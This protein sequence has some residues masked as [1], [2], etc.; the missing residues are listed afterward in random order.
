MAKTSSGD[1]S[2]NVI[3]LCGTGTTCPDCDKKFATKKKL[4]LHRKL[5]H[6]PDTPQLTCIQC[7]K[8]FKVMSNLR[9]HRRA[10]HLSGQSRPKV[11]A[12]SCHFCDYKCRDQFQLSIHLRRHTRDRPFACSRCQQ[13]FA[14]RADCERHSGRCP[15]RPRN[16]CPTCS[17]TF[18]NIK[19]LN[20]H[21]LWDAN[22]G[23]LRQLQLPTSS[24][25]TASVSSSS[26]DALEIFRLQ[27]TDSDSDIV[28]AR[29]LRPNQ[30]S[31]VPGGD[32]GL[33]AASQRRVRCGV[34]INCSRG[35]EAKPARC[36]HPVRY[37]KMAEDDARSATVSRTQKEEEANCGVVV[38]PSRPPDTQDGTRTFPLSGADVEPEEFIMEEECC[39]SDPE[40]CHSEDLLLGS[41]LSDVILMKEEVSYLDSAVIT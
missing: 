7:D 23:R 28:G 15:G 13:A 2:D 3:P 6:E 38:A 41:E 18:R 32:G 30:S 29:L 20:Q 40:H 4:N 34:C 17:Q 21:F 24:G 12:A 11:K 31:A 19:L 39:S 25:D 35:G 27:T 1:K 26:A 5:C 33:V 37:Y 10:V 22:C 36:L 16:A 9:R 8:S 14:S